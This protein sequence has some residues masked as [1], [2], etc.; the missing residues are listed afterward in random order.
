MV[1]LAW[2]ALYYLPIGDLAH[3]AKLISAILGAAGVTALLFLH[4][5]AVFALGVCIGRPGIRDLGTQLA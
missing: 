4:V 1:H 2:Q 3:R 5:L